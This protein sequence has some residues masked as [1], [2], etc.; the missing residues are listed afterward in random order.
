VL[1]FKLLAKNSDAITPVS[2]EQNH[3]VNR[4]REQE[5]PD[6]SFKMKVDPAVWSS[7]PG[8]IIPPTPME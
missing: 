7:R 6:K 1:T 4:S 8:I 5:Y 3:N 2:G